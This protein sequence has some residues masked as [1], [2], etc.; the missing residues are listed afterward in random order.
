ME[1][2]DLDKEHDAAERNEIAANDKKRG[3]T[4]LR[5]FRFDRARGGQSPANSSM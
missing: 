5:M 3:N 4:F 2:D 1:F